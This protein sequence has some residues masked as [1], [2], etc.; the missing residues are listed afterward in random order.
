MR[1]RCIKSIAVFDAVSL[2]K[3]KKKKK[4]P[5]FPPPREK[6]TQLERERA[7]DHMKNCMSCVF[8]INGDAMLQIDASKGGLMDRRA[9]T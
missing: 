6:C 5:L 3:K 7:L 9:G 8:H 4:K 2:Q 1:V